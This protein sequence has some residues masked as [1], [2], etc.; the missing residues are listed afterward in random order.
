MFMGCSYHLGY[1][2]HGIMTQVE[3]SKN[4]YK[5]IGS[6][7]G[8]AQATYWFGIG[9]SQQN[10]V[11]QARRDMIKKANLTGGSKA[12]INVTSDEKAN[13]FIFWHKKTVYVS[14]EVIEFV[15]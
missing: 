2:G 5:V 14:G 12:V 7:T 11:D 3:L 4:N 1:V 8:E 6:V 10:L 9:P 13:F 15:S